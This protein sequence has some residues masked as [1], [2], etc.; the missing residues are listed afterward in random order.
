MEQGTGKLI[1]QTTCE[2][3]N[4]DTEKQKQKSQRRNHVIAWFQTCYTRIAAVCKLRG[5][6]LRNER[7]L[8]QRTR[9]DR[10]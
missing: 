7:T 1:C 4:L 8:T 2:Q 10:V 5:A 3:R 6:A 9:V